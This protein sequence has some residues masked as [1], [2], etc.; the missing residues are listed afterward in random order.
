MRY[1]GYFHGTGDHGDWIGV[2]LSVDGGTERVLFN[3]NQIPE[4]FVLLTPAEHVFTYPRP[5]IFSLTGEA[6]SKLTIKF[7]PA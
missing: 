2:S 1:F 3:N 5:C 6:L 4:L 7:P